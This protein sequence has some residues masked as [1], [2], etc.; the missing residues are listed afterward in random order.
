MRDHFLA[1][2]NRLLE[3]AAL[4]SKGVYDSALVDANGSPVLET[5]TILFGGAPDSLGDDR[6]TGVAVAGSDASYT[7]MVRSVSPSADGVRSAMSKVLTQLVGFTPAI[8]G[9][10]C[11][12][13]LFDFASE[14]RADNAVSPP[15]F[16]VDSDFVLKSS[17][18]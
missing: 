10:R 12:P 14:V 7:Y 9:R 4:A 5:Y 1:V 8:G 11:S 18:L 3:D 16:Y 13:I 2:K 15:L 6:L 17:H